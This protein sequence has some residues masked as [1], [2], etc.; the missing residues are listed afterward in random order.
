MTIASGI[1]RKT[2]F[3]DT[4]VRDPF[5]NRVGNLAGITVGAR[6]VVPVA[7]FRAEARH[8]RNLFAR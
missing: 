4:V 6:T 8:R 7:L 2:G 3:T 5:S 1:I